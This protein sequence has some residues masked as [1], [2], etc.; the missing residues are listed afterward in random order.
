MS[1]AT[2]D[3][4]SDRNPVRRPV[5]GAGLK[6]AFRFCFAGPV[7]SCMTRRLGDPLSVLNQVNLVNSTRNVAIAPGYDILRTCLYILR[8]PYSPRTSQKKW[9]GSIFCLKV[10]KA[11]KLEAGSLRNSNRRAP[12]SK[13]NSRLESVWMQVITASKVTVELCVRSLNQNEPVAQW[14]DRW[15]SDQ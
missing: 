4:K 13:N 6:L 9:E 1:T 5:R 8:K 11:G 10:K 2:E 12:T 7:Y 15:T 3:I 14:L